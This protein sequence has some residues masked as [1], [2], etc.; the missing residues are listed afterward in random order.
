MT[1]LLAALVLSLVPV[2]DGTPDYSASPLDP[3]EMEQ[4]LAAC[5]VTFDK[6]IELAV[7]KVPG[8]VVEAD[9]HDHGGVLQYEIIIG[10]NGT[11]KRVV[12]NSTSGEVFAP[13]LD[14]KGAMAAARAKVDGQFMSV[15]SDQLADPPTYTA[16]VFHKGKIHTITLSAVDGAITSSTVQGRFPGEDTG[17]KEPVA[18]PS[19]LQYVDLVEGTGAQPSGPSARVRVHYTGYF[20]DGKVFDSSVSRGQPAEFPL[21]GVIKGWTEGVGSMKVGGKRKLIIPFQLAYGPEGRPGAIPPKATL[22]FDVELIS[23]VSDPGA[24]PAPGK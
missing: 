2:A 10:G 23:I 5:P 3:A 18:L 14:L 17:D 9:V 4:R 24:A 19:G 16:R 22:F 11:I 8:M 15:V 7:A 21:G 1:S 6:A 12:V 20:N 13:A